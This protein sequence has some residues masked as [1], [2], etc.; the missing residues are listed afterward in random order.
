LPLIKRVNVVTGRGTLKLVRQGTHII[1]KTLLHVVHSG[2][3]W[4]MNG[5]LDV[6]AKISKLRVQPIKLIVNSA[7]A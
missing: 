6:S 2:H 5:V 1:L 4:I 7:E 3:D